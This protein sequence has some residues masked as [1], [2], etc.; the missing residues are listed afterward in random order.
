MSGTM[1]DN[2]QPAGWRMWADDFL[3]HIFTTDEPTLTVGARAILWAMAS[4]DPRRPGTLPNDPEQL[5]K[6]A[7]VTP[8]QWT[9]IWPRLQRS[10]KFD[11]R[12]KRWIVRRIQADSRRRRRHSE[13]RSKATSKQWRRRNNGD[14]KK[15]DARAETGVVQVHESPPPSLPPPLSRSRERP[16]PKPS[17][18]EPPSAGFFAS[19]SEE[20][21]DAWRKLR[22][23]LKEKL[24]KD[25]FRRL[26]GAVNAYLAANPPYEVAMQA[27]ES[28][29]KAK[30]MRTPAGL[31]C[32][33]V[34]IQ[35]P[36]Y[37]E[38]RHIEEH[39]RRL[40]EDIEQEGQEE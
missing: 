32:S 40:A 39:R 29:L 33:I 5:R 7:R 17:P 4:K 10:W 11:R 14:G 6:W 13:Q 24:G 23:R 26:G 2:H 21:T 9:D 12:S 1:R 25:N 3:T 18:G 36:N 15:I 28:V 16:P 20:Q 8:K 35:E 22:E 38:Q 19:L 30:D 34:K 37:H 31:F 27:L